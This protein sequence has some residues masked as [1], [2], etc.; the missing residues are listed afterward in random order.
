MAWCRSGH[1]YLRVAI[2][3]LLLAGVAPARAESLLID[4]A[5]SHAGFA[6]R[7]LWIKRIEGQFARVEGVIERDGQSGRFGVDVR[8][9]AASV[10]MASD[11]HA[12]WARSADFFDALHHPWIQFRA[13]A[14]PEHLLHDGGEVRGNLTLRGVTR[15]MSFILA[16]TECPR[17]GLDCVVRASGEVERSQFGMNA[18]RLVLGDRVRIDFAIR[19]HAG[20]GRA[21]TQDAG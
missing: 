21:A 8:I 14:L 2:A 19:A 7:A 15:A 5:Q 6:L 16:P 11:D 3:L 18:R 10:K 4:T 13:E 12:D 20:D 1:R 9:A 17:P